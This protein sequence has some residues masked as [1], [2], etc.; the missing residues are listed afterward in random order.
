VQRQQQERAVRI[1]GFGELEAVVMDRLW[2]R[3]EVSTVR[4]IFD[5]LAETRPIAYTT[6][7]STLDNLHRKGWLQRELVGKA[8]HYR[9]KMTREEHSAKLMRDAFDGGGDAD[10]VLTHF[11]KQMNDDESAQLQAAL[12]RIVK[13]R[14]RS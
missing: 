4:E 3:T 10:L 6:V 1:R 11:L 5:E 2:S 13:R 9:P 7:L 14:P 12:R 8:Y